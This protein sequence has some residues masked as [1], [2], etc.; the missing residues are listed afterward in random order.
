MPTPITDRG[1]IVITYVVSGLTHTFTMFTGEPVLTA[2]VWRIPARPST[3]GT[4]DW[5]DAADSLAEAMS[6]MLDTGATAGGAVLY[7]YDGV[8]WNP[9]DTESVT[10]PNV[11]GSPKLAAQYTA[12]FRDEGFH[13]MKPTIMEGNETVPSHFV[14]STGGGT[15][16][17]NWLLEWTVAHT[18]PVAP[19]DMAQSIWGEHVRNES[20]VSG[21][22][23]YNRVLRKAR[24][25][26]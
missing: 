7:K 17:D 24:G 20:F 25:L 14:S 1:K 15:S 26:A 16:W 11:A 10:F 6:N 9:L 5:G 4:A 21:T 19:Y 12:V 2:G 3:G 22:S 13:L 18:L 8:L 23:T